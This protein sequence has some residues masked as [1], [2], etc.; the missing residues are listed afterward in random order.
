[1]LRAVTSGAMTHGEASALVDRARALV[2]SV[3]ARVPGNAR[4]W[5]NVEAFT[6]DGEAWRRDH[7]ELLLDVA[8]LRRM[9]ARFRTFEEPAAAN[10]GG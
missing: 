4:L 3:R 5:L 7:A 1:M 6:Q 10:A 9:L 2:A 8:I